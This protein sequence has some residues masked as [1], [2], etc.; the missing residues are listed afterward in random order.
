MSPEHPIRYRVISSE[1]GMPEPG[2][3][4]QPLMRLFFAACFF[5]AIHRE[6]I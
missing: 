3:R 1:S 5:A 6:L 2:F 4:A